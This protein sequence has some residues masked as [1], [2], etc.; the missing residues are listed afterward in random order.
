MALGMKLGADH[1]T[2]VGPAVPHNKRMKLTK[3]PS[4]EG[5]RAFARRPH[6]VALRSLSVC[7]ADTYANERARS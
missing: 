2:A 3:R 4:F 1:H 6:Q 7:S 5:R